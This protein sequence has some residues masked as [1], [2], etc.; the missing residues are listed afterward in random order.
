MPAQPHGTAWQLPISALTEWSTALPQDVHDISMQHFSRLPP[1]DLLAA[2]PLCQPFSQ[3]GRMDGFRCHKAWVFPE[4][5]N[6]ILQLCSTIGRH[7]QHVRECEGN[8]CGRQ[9]HL[10]G[11][12]VSLRPHPRA[13]L[14]RTQGHHVLDQ[15]GPAEPTPAAARPAHSSPLHIATTARAAWARRQV[16]PPLGEWRILLQVGVLPRLIRSPY[17]ARRQARTLHA[18]LQ[19]RPPGPCAGPC[20]PTGA[21]HG[22]Q[23]RVD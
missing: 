9:H 23:R 7:D 19:Y 6:I 10:H 20:V 16:Q 14:R 1:V 4:V 5:V 18:A 3:A 11:G 2:G 13:W 17:A 21:V 22:T 8:C 12:T 15:H